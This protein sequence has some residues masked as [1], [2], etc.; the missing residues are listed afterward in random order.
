MTRGTIILSI[1]N[2]EHAGGGFASRLNAVLLHKFV[3]MK[4]I[5]SFAN[6]QCSVPDLRGRRV[7][8]CNIRCTLNV[9]GGDGSALFQDCAIGQHGLSCRLWRLLSV[10]SSW[11]SV[12]T[13]GNQSRF[14]FLCT[15][16]CSHRAMS[17]VV[18]PWC[19]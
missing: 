3:H 11:R 9:H 8:C 1:L 10:L 6:G 13:Y 7:L 18:H 19:S 16:L 14:C 12:L 5:I 2:M 15:N 17:S 4:P